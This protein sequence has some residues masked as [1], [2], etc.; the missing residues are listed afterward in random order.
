MA[1]KKTKT[2]EIFST[3]DKIFLLNHSIMTDMIN[4]SFDEEI[5]RIPKLNQSLEDQKFEQLGSYFQTLRKQIRECL[6]IGEEIIERDYSGLSQEA[7]DEM[8]LQESAEP[9]RAT[10]AAHCCRRKSPTATENSIIYSFS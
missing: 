2:Q 7:I 5:S 10:S 3:L 1:D 4:A 8:V 9:T 6:K